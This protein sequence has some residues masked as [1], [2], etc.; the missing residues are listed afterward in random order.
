M[1]CIDPCPIFELVRRGDDGSYKKVCTDLEQLSSLTAHAIILSETKTDQTWVSIKRLEQDT[2]KAIHLQ[3]L[4]LRSTK[5]DGE[6]SIP[7]VIGDYLLCGKLVSSLHVL[8]DLE[9]NIGAYF[10]FEGL[11][12]NIEGKYILRICVNDLAMYIFIN[13]IYSCEQSVISRSLCSIDTAPFE[14]FSPGAKTKR[15]G[16]LIQRITLIRVYRY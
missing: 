3:Q 1:E 7:Q 11:S 15:K 6:E 4:R 12:V 16:I 9:G 10:V 13:Y 2:T 5:R 8:T 14:C